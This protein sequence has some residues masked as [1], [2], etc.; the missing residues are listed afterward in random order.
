MMALTFLPHIMD[1]F[2]SWFCNSSLELS[3]WKVCILQWALA[4]YHNKPLPNLSHLT[5]KLSHFCYIPVRVG[6]SGQLYSFSRT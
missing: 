4:T 5:P 3:K 2:L 6:M 1:S